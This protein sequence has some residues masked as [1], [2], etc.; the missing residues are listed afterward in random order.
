[1]TLPSELSDT[2]G[3]TRWAGRYPKKY[4]ED[5]ARIQEI[6]RTALKRGTNGCQVGHLRGNELLEITRWKHSG[7]RNDSDVRWNTETAVKEK[8][9]LAF[10]AEDYRCLSGQPPKGLKGVGVP[11]ASAIMHFAFPDKYPIIDENALLCLGVLSLESNKRLNYSHKLWC[12]YQEKCLG[13]REKYEIDSLRTLDRA[14][15]MY[16]DHLKEQKRNRLKECK[17][18]DFAL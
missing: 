2:P 16:G 17:G 14:L 9:H 6:V 4:L 15:W 18:R 3:I 7:C 11:T 12:R 13:W 1:M 10:V 8:S 5:D